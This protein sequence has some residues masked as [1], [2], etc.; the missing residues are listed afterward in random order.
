MMPKLGAISLPGATSLGVCSAAPL[1]EFDQSRCPKTDTERG[2]LSQNGQAHR[3][4]SP[5]LARGCVPQVNPTN[6]LEYNKSEAQS[7]AAAALA[8]ASKNVECRCANMY[9]LT[10]V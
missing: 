2:E 4:S 6:A 7:T 9:V 5:W 8:S 10:A 1:C 3:K